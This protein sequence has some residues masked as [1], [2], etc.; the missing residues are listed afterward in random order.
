MAVRYDKKFLSEIRGIK[1]AFNRK[2][3]RLTREGK[4]NV[5]KRFSSEAFKNIVLSSHNRRE[6]RR[7]LKDYQTFTKKGGEELITVGNADIPKFKLENVKRYRRLLKYQTTV[8]LKE[9]ETRKPIAN[10][11]VQPFTFAQYGTQDYLTFRAKR[12]KLLSKN[13]DTMDEQELDEYLHKL[14]SNTRSKNLDVWQSNY[15]DI[16]QDTALSY[17]YDPEKLEVIVSALQRMTPEDFDDLSFIDSNIKQVI[18][19]YKSLADITSQNAYLKNAGDAISNLDS[20]Y[21]NLNEIL[22]NYNVN[23]DDIIKKI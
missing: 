10:G 5:P 22:A 16:L 8:K 23:I 11:K 12:E 9:F 13:I 4:T 17:G 6:V 1:A 15:I 20:I 7:R 3:A 2:V 21:D 14:I 18:Y 19:G